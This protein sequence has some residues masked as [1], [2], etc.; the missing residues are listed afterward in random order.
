MLH[1]EGL[2]KIKLNFDCLVDVTI[3]GMHEWLATW[4]NIKN[5]KKKF[6]SKW[7]ISMEKTH[8]DKK[9]FL[10]ICLKLF[11]VASHPWISIYIHVYKMVPI[12]VRALITLLLLYQFRSNFADCTVTSSRIYITNFWAEIIPQI[13]ENW[14][15]RFHFMAMCQIA[16]AIL[17]ATPMAICQFYMP[18]LA[19]RILQSSDSIMSFMKL[20]VDMILCLL[21][22]SVATY[23]TKKICRISR[24]RKDY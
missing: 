6:F 4:N 7:V 15:N 11:Q 17:H 23:G 3:M 13:A 9:I 16:W 18:P 5:L 10:Q 20:H 24:I 19:D 8:F 14:I 1:Q 12:I 21:T 22:F 2:K